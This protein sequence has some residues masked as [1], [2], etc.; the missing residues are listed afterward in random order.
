MLGVCAVGIE[1]RARWLG[2]RAG[3]YLLSICRYVCMYVSVCVYMY[4]CMYVCM[5][6]CIYAFTHIY[7]GTFSAS[8]LVSWA[9]GISGMDADGDALAGGEEGDALSHNSIRRAVSA[10]ACNI[11]IFVHI[12]SYLHKHAHTHTHPT[13]T[14]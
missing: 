1:Q 11:C 12:S 10:F 6:E 3:E 13:A 9:A 5:Y 8:W 2:V 7:A 14:Y 4:V